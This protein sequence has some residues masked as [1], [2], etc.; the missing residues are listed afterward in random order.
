MRVCVCEDFLKNVW[1]SLKWPK[2]PEFSRE[3]K[4]K[5][6]RPIKSQTLFY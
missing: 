3:E 1:I 4:K 2:S 6:V 5:S